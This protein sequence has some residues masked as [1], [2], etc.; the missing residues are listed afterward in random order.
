LQ[1]DLKTF[2]A[3][4]AYGMS[5]VTVVTAQNSARVEAVHPLSP[6]L[7]IAQLKAVLDDYGAAAIKTGFLGQPGLVTTVAALLQDHPVATSA[8]IIVDPVLVNHRA[9]P[10]FGADMTRAYVEHLLP[11]CDLVTP[12]CAE[13]ALLTGRAVKGVAGMRQAAQRVHDM[14]AG[15]VLITGGQEGAD[16]VDVFYDGQEVTELRARRID[17][18]NT[19]GAGDTFSAA[20]A[21]FLA[22]GE[23]MVDAVRDARQFTLR[24]IA[25]AADWRL[26][27][28]H[29][30]L[31]HL[32]FRKE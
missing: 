22:R 9:R 29:G 17:T 20:V 15:H 4:G 13:A 5:V 25:G 3:L 27:S 32:S 18:E 28:G 10:M 24:A 19:H 12:N 8:F 1:A 30:P 23:A 16:V 11:L 26:G 7:V 21:V 6:E 31:N 2:T 14:G